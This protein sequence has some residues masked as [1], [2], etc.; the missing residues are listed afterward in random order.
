MPCPFTPH[1]GHGNFFAS[2]D[3]SKSIRRLVVSS[4]TLDTTHGACRPNA[5]VNRAST[6]TLTD[7][8]SSQI[9]AITAYHHFFATSRHGRRHTMPCRRPCPSVL[10]LH[11]VKVSLRRPALTHSPPLT[12]FRASMHRLDVEHRLT[13][14]LTG[15]S[16]S[17]Y[18]T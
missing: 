8:S 4:S 16:G 1:A 11:S 14:N 9:R 18:G 5:E 10:A 17:H 2:Q 3:T 12:L 13:K 6:A 15:N 7:D